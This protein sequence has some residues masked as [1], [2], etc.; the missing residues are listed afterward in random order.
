MT[1]SPP[2]GSKFTRASL[3]GNRYRGGNVPGGT[4]QVQEDLQTS[5]QCA[6]EPQAPAQQHIV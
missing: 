1:N 5:M 3:Q 6:V 4:L 2:S